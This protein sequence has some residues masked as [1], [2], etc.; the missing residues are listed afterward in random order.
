[1]IYFECLSSIAT[2]YFT[3]MYYE[4]DKEWGEMDEDVRRLLAWMIAGE[5]GS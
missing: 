4:Q 2:A 5:R 1:M 3:W